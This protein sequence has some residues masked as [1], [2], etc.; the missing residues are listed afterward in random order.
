MLW[1]GPAKAADFPADPASLGPI[2]AGSGG[3]PSCEFGPPRDVSFAAGGLYG[4]IT[5]VGVTIAFSPQH[6]YVG[7]LSVTLI[8]PGGESATV[9]SRTRSGED[10][11]GSDVAGP[12]TFSDSA[13]E[14]TSWWMAAAALQPDETI[15]PGAY[16]ASTPGPGGG[17]NALLTRAFAA[18]NP[19]GVWTLRVADTCLA[20]TGGVGAATLSLNT[21][22]PNAF[23]FG[24]AK[25]NKRKGTAKLEVAIEAPGTIDLAAGK[26]KAASARAEAPGVVVLAIKAKGKARKKLKSKGKAKVNAAVTFTPDGGLPATQMK[27]LKLVRK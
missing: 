11:S 25:R 15:P 14:T 23:T 2:P 18:A 6:N 19:N 13:Q 1:A 21:E 7:D 8:A 12:Y 5:D 4:P 10:G 16:R 20:D 3:G 22:P 17:A 27:K 26:V 24:K 9:F